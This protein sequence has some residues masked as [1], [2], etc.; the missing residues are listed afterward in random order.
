MNPH[1]KSN[2]SAERGFSLAEM[3]VVVAIIGIMTLVLVPNFISMY[4][5]GKFKAS[6]RTLT[7]SLRNARQIAISANTRTKVSFP[8]TGT[9]PRTFVIEQQERDIQAGTT[10]WR[11]VRTGDL[12]QSVTFTDTG[13]LDT[14]T[15]DGGLR[16]IIFLPNGTIENLPLAEA[17]RF[18]EISTTIKVPKKVYRLSFTPSGN[19]TLS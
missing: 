15:G 12:G 9:T 4:N 3:L 5:S 16:D 7:S 10:S 14:V 19:V 1:A 17:N 8:I 18:I 6:A 2:R 13:F 11:R